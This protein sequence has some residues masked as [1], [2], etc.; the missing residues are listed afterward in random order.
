MG[1]SPRVGPLGVG[2]EAQQVAAGTEADRTA[3][4][5][6]GEHVPEADTLPLRGEADRE[7]IGLG[8][9]VAGLGPTPDL[10]EG[11]PESSAGGL[12]GG[13][14]APGADFDP[15]TA[16]PGRTPDL[17]GGAATGTTIRLDPDS[18][19]EGATDVGTVTGFADTT[20]DDTTAG[21]GSIPDR[22]TTAGIGTVGEGSRGGETQGLSGTS[23]AEKRPT[24]PLS[25]RGPITG[26]SEPTP[27]RDASGPGQEENAE[28]GEQTPSKDRLGPEVRADFVFLRPC[29][30]VTVR[31]AAEE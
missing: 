23:P 21:R 8:P 18:N 15:G 10:D 17:A 30:Q 4:A 27:D 13:L 2:R 31:L 1:A 7:D 9:D 19:L 12:Q 25:E 3:P 28:L 26:A 16:G 24:A 14:P 6:E 22:G 20:Q 29:F 5:S 11:E